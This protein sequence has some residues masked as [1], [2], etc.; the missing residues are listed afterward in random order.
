MHFVVK[1]NNIK[2]L[3]FSSL[4][5]ILVVSVVAEHQQR[6]AQVFT[7]GTNE[8]KVFEDLVEAKLK[9]GEKVVTIVNKVNHKVD[10]QCKSGSEIIAR[11]EVKQNNAYQFSFNPK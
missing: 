3:K 9:E 10:V 2:M 6:D 7:P 11:K 1:V 5:F 8:A 4:L